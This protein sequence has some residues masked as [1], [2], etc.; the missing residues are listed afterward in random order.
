MNKFE[1]KQDVLLSLLGQ[2]IFNAPF[3]PNPD[4]DWNEVIKEGFAQSVALLAFKNYKALPIDEE[5]KKKI[6]VLLLQSVNYNIK[7]FRNHT[8]LHSLMESNGISYCILKGA[9]SANYYADPL[10]RSMGDV[11]FY[12]SPEDL[13]RA[14]EVLISNGFENANHNHRF[15]VLFHKGKFAFEMHFDPIAIPDGEVGKVYREYWSDICKE[16]VAVS[17]DIVECR[18]PSQF[19]HGFILLSHFVSHLL[20]EGIGLRHLCDWAVF[21]DRF[22]NSEFSNIF[23]K[24]LKRAGLWRIAQLICLAAVDHMGMTYREWMGDDHET[25]DKLLNDVLTGGNFGRKDRRRPYQGFFISFEKM[26]GWRDTR[27]V[28]VIKT[29]NRLTDSNWRC[30]KK[31]PLLYP[32]GWVYFSLRFIVRRITGKR[33][34]SIIEAYKK[35]EER[36]NIYK[37]M[38]LFEPEE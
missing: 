27:I 8:Y 35:S 33:K 21:A 17:N 10:L 12:V 24:K 36:K 38:G 20:H 32:V 18:V 30:A 14:T 22:S 16:S 34:V 6:N 9:A 31:F 2:T 13:E 25:A 19:M 37:D 3:E 4:V 26:E 29:L 11:D 1:K 28:Q 23:E 7:C 5:T 15:H